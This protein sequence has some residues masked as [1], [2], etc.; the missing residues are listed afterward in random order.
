MYWNDWNQNPNKYK[1]FKI[2]NE[3][4]EKFDSRKEYNRY[5]ELKLLERSGE[6]SNL[7]RQVRYELI[8]SQ[9]EPDTIGPRGGI[10]K[11][12]VIE[13][14]VYYYADFQYLDKNGNLVVEDAKSPA[15][16]TTAYIIKRK[17]MLEK[18]HI[19]IKEI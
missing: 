12:K 10:K 2:E 9:R 3:D 19:R 8:P 4:G 15:T 14:P 1:N 16:R 13:H 18:H 7:Q 11:G 6:I 5:M 17:L